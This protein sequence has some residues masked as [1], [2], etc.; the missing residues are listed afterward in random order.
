MKI[1][2]IPPKILTMYSS[3]MDAEVLMTSEHVW[4]GVETDTIDS[5]T[6]L[7]DNPFGL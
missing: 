5:D 4:D 7:D 3:S 6:D 2:Y 1:D